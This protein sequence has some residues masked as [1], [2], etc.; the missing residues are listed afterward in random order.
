MCCKHNLL[1]GT[2]KE[3][4][5]IFILVFITILL[6]LSLYSET[7]STGYW[8]EIGKFPGMLDYLLHILE[9][10]APKSPNDDTPFVIPIMW[11]LVSSFMLFSVSF[12]PTKELDTVGTNTIFRYKSRLHWWMGKVIWNILTTLIVYSVFIVTILFFALLTA[13][14]HFLAFTP[15]LHP[16]LCYSDSVASIKPF[17]IV[18]IVCMPVLIYIT[19]GLVH[20]AM[21]QIFGPVIAYIALMACYIVSAYVKNPLLFFSGSML[22]R[23]N[24]FSQNGISPMIYL[25]FSLVFGTIAV[26]LGHLLFQQYDIL[27]RNQ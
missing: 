3:W 8:A 12:Y 9:G 1:L 26:L 27:K 21:S 20:M 4:K 24:I 11:L 2:F 14:P 18:T 15:E 5:K 13:G 19:V 7:F 16:Y 6:C 23:Y 10:V 17:E 25:A 22:K